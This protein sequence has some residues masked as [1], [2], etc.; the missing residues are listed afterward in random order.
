MK[1]LKEYGLLLLIMIGLIV[2]LVVY[3]VRGDDNTKKIDVAVL[4]T[5]ISELQDNS[6]WC[7]TFQLIWNDL[8]DEVIKKDIE[9]ISDKGNQMVLDLN[10]ETFTDNML[11]PEYYYKKYGFATT[12][13]KKEIE[14][15]IKEKFNEDSDILDSFNFTE[16]SEDYFFYSM[17]VRSFTFNKPF[18]KLSD[19]NFGIDHDSSQEL[20]ENVEV[21]FYQDSEHYAV[22]L[23]TTSND[24]V[25]LYKGERG[26]TFNETY[27]KIVKDDKV[28]S[29]DSHDTLTV[30]N[31]DFRTESE[32]ESLTKKEFFDIDGQGYMIDKIIQTII[33][34]LDN[35]GGK[36][37]SEAGMMMKATAVLDEEARYF[38]FSDDFVLF[39]KEQDK[40]VP[41]L[42]VNINDVK[43]FR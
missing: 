29:F 39:L 25:I 21:L 30:A 36:V 28:R 15:A 5:M 31:L 12:T 18:D 27:Q 42:A 24:E 41:Y 4:P 33:F 16:N 43:N 9:F 19:E 17:L 14:K 22:K 26:N 37:K 38:N 34:K 35:T 1:Y 32:Y 20:Y 8:K 6:A 2:L 13:L 11:S 7:P 10:K 40:N 3:Y 23:L